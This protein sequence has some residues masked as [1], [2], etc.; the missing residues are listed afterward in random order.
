MLE[1]IFLIVADFQDYQLPIF[2][3]PASRASFPDK[4]LKSTTLD[5]QS[6]VEAKAE[7]IYEE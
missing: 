4:F 2:I 7:I 1:T 3:T 6:C 5:N